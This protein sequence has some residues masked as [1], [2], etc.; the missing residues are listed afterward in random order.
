M[1]RVS[2]RHHG[3]PMFVLMSGMFVLMPGMFE[4]MFMYAQMFTTVSSSPGP[5]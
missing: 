3:R 2:G 5:V 4:Q 1:D